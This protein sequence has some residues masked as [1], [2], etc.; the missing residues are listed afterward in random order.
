VDLSNLELE[1]FVVGG[2]HHFRGCPDT[3]GLTSELVVPAEGTEFH[4]SCSHERAS[5]FVSSFAG[6]H[7]DLVD[8]LMGVEATRKLTKRLETALSTL[9]DELAGLAPKQL[10]KRFRRVAE[11]LSDARD[12]LGILVDPSNASTPEVSALARECTESLEDLGEDL[13]ALARSAGLKAVLDAHSFKKRRKES[14]KERVRDLEQA[15]TS[16]REQLSRPV[17]VVLPEDFLTDSFDPLA[18]L[19]FSVNPGHANAVVLPLATALECFSSCGS[20]AAAPA[21]PAD[22]SEVLET[23]SRLWRDGGTTLKAALRTARAL[24][25]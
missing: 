3:S 18:F 12:A 21:K 6:G 2:L 13:G 8:D 23:A 19:A 9:A 24:S 25:A 4:A 17:L 5:L 22:S 14:P 16:S 15:V 1:L 20:A 10:L 11:L 7:S